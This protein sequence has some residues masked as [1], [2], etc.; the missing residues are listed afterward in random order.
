MILSIHYAFQL[1]GII[2]RTTDP[3]ITKLDLPDYPNL[4]AT[5][6]SFKV[7]EIRRTLVFDNLAPEVS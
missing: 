5:T 4:P 2:L 6:E 7:N 3:E 1:D